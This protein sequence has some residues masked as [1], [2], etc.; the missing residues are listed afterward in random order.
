MLK[1]KSRE[2]ANFRIGIQN[3]SELPSAAAG[4]KKVAET[5]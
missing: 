5:F 1:F 4:V 3:M 2:K